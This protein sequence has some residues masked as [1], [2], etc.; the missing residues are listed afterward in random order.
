MLSIGKLVVG[1][2]RYYEQQVAHGRDDY[3]SGR[4]E[5]PGEWF[6]AG[7]R[8][9]G[10]QGRVSAEQFNALIAGADP[11][12]L[13]ARLRDGQDP[14][15]AALDL[16]FSAPK[17]VSVLFAIAGEEVAGEMV[18]AH[19]AAVDA[20]VGWI[21]GTSVLVRRGPQGHI[22][23]AGE[24]LIAAAYRHRMSRALDPQLHT[25]VVAANLARGP[26]G[27]FTAL[28]GTP[29]YQAAKTAGYLYQA[30]LRAEVSERLGLEWGPVGKGAAELKDVPLAVLE[31]FSR[32]RHE[33]QRAAAEGGFPLD[34]KRSAE[35]AAVD[36]RERKQ[37]GIETHT[38]QEEIEA[39]AA[40]HGLGRDEVASLR[41]RGAERLSR[42]DP[43]PDHAASSGGGAEVEME[44]ELRDLADR[45]A[46]SCGLTERSNT[47]DDR[48]VLREFA[49][50]ADQGARVATVR[51]RAEG[52]TRRD[53]VLRTL[54]GGMT[55]ADLVDCEQRLIEAAAGRSEESCAIVSPAAI[56]RALA[57]ADRPLTADQEQVVCGC[58]GSGH[59]VDVVEAL[60]GTGKTY[61]AGVL[62]SLYENAGYAV[63]GV[64]PTGRGARELG[65]EGRDRVADDRPRA[66]R[67]RTARRRPPR[68][69]R[70]R[71]RRSRHGTN[72]YHG[73]AARARR[74]S[75]S[76]GDRDRRFRPASLSSRR[77]LASSRRRADRSARA[78]RGHAAARSRRAPRA[79]S[80][81]RSAAGPVH[82][83]GGG[84]RQDRRRPR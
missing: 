64:A 2:Q 15:V 21:E 23:L 66:D 65:D 68:P 63:I 84:E 12:D 8:A 34:T 18:A 31:E 33:M 10:L 78:D 6:G 32:R 5:A 39:R 47:F 81:A 27:R 62:R 76:E 83:V 24:G 35:A 60:A 74:A 55:T 11:R 36:T 25:H 22:R 46:G 61:T 44:V 72:A 19:E 14:K 26:D 29:I 73:A 20:A 42:S 56:D 48:A 16:T 58:A 43:S 30:H 40:E 57:N 7:A 28:F 1:Q 70:D 50:A 13:S 53:D 59:G 38:W 71:A 79:W 37:Y 80:A 69:S 52:F 49:Q 4:G 41:T 77:R 9:L 45:L 75:W 54:D 82:R 67:H 3:Y 51:G 17:S